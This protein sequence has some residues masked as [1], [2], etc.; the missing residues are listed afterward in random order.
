[1][2]LRV[3]VG[4]K[5]MERDG[6]TEPRAAAPL[7]RRATPVPARTDYLAC[8]CEADRAVGPY[9]HIWHFS[10]EKWRARTYSLIGKA[11]SA[12]KFSVLV[13]L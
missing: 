2:D 4:M 8:V 5:C 10:P 7:A 13:R 3:Y 9:Q 6:N 12:S 11:Y 1:M